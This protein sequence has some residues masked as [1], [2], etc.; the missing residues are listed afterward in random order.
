M[1]DYVIY[2]HDPDGREV[3]GVLLSNHHERAWLYRRDY[4]AI[5]VAFG[6][7]R[8]YANSNGQGSAYVRL[9]DPALRNNRTVARLVL[10]NPVRSVI[11]YRDRN[12][13]NLRST[14][15]EMEVGAGGCPKRGR[16]SIGLVPSK[17]S[18]GAAPQAH[19]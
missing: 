4:E 5:V 10:G 13:L 17:P 1:T 11:R 19:A 7:G 15:L 12:R 16:R 8:W 18:A 9:T 14:N 3:A 6:N 2:S